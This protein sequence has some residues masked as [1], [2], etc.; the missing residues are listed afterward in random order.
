MKKRSHYIVFDFDF[1]T[2]SEDAPFQEINNGESSYFESQQYKTSMSKTIDLPSNII[3]IDKAIITVGNI[4]FGGAGSHET[5]LKDKIREF[6]E[7]NLFTNAGL[8][9]IPTS[10]HLFYQQ[11]YKYYK[12]KCFEIG[13][14]EKNINNKVKIDIE[15]LITAEFL[16]LENLPKSPVLDYSIK[17]ILKCSSNK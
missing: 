7:I 16:E 11:H 3:S 17:I 8:D 10:Y 13:I 12:Q 14:G 2:Y 4:R 9:F 5:W 6:A 1:R 15:N